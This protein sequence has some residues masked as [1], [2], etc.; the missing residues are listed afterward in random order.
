MA[1]VTVNWHVERVM[2]EADDK[3]R[4]ALLGIAFEIEGQTKINIRENDQIDTGFMLNSVY[5]TS[6]GSSGFG[7]AAATASTCTRST[8]GR[9]AV[10]HQ[11]DMA[12]EVALPDKNVIGIVVGAAYAI[13]QENL[14]AFLYPAVRQVAKAYGVRPKIR[15]LPR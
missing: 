8:K 11:N 12:P 7:P 2:L 9:G 14:R 3:A 4:Q 10:D 1:D 13:Y 5:V 15:L 6:R